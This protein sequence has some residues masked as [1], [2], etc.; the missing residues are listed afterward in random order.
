MMLPLQSQ[1]YC[2]LF[3]HFILWSTTGPQLQYSHLASAKIHCMT[4]HCQNVNVT[5]RKTEKDGQENRVL[6]SDAAGMFCPKQTFINSKTHIYDEVN[7][8]TFWYF[9]AICK[10]QSKNVLFPRQ[11]SCWQGILG[12]F[13]SFTQTCTMMET[14]PSTWET[15]QVHF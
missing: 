14:G 15:V 1:E 8:T 12:P 3:K 13:N 4:A 11:I 6:L 7:N 9:K 5:F 2:H 10:N